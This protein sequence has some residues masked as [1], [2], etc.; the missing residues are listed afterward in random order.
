MKKKN[1]YGSIRKLIFTSMILVPF[2]PFILIVGMGFYHFKG[3]IEENTLA[4]MNRIAKD[5]SQMIGGFLDEKRSD[6]ELIASLH[7]FEELT[8][9]TKLRRVFDRLQIK[10]RAYV[11]LGVFNARGLHVAYHGPFSLTGKN[12]EHEPW[13]KNVMKHGYYV[14]DVFLGY[15]NIPHFIVAIATG[16]GD[17]KW[18][19]RATIDSH[20][21]CALVSAVHMGATGEA[22][23]LNRDGI[24]QTMRRSGGALMEK[25]PGK[26]NLVSFTRD[27]NTFIREDESGAVYLY[28]TARMKEKSWLLVVRQGQQDA[29]RI[30]NQTVVFTMVVMV[31]G[32]VIILITALYMTGRI[33]RKLEQTDS[34]KKQ[35]S[36]QLIGASRLAELGE[37]AAGFA[38]EINNPLQIIKSE[39]TLVEM[40][41]SELKEKGE[42]K[43]S[44]SLSEILDSMDQ[45]KVQI[46]RCATITQAILKFGRQSEFSDQDVDLKI[47]IPEAVE[48][49]AKKAEVE[50][51]SIKQ[52]IDETTGAVHG[53]PAQLQQ[54]LLNFFNNA[55]HAIH[56]KHGSLGGELII[57]AGPHE[58]K[59]V[60]VKVKDNGC[61]I[62]PENME[63]I[64]SPFFTT[65]PVGEGTGLGLSVC[66]GIIENMG[67]VMSVS[68]K[69][70]QGTVFSIQLPVSGSK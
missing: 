57:E 5:H 6:L 38:H 53:D 56:E 33:V 10:S 59:T 44:E 2:V 64:F 63:Q 47:F 9:P 7:T 51:I 13:F 22:Y 29:F 1:G 20:T 12:Y 4:H 24:F 35:L 25:S 39:Q 34:E 17:Q 27:I 8:D 58:N 41:F 65:K 16:T 28:A 69:E 18:A 36:H 40:L 42:L 70:G 30:L 14:S 23:I 66:Y 62:K 11:D 15:R 19:L 46:S 48:M 43:E 26:L 52:Y 49:V 54:V 31:M 37:M 68:S 61:G 67:G 55:I 45:I 32:G 50:G 3:S 21:F 60:R